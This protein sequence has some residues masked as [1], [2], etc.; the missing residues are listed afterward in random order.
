MMRND[1][2]TARHTREKTHRTPK[3]QLKAQ[4]LRKNWTQVY[5]ATMIG[6]SDVEVSRWE[7][8]AA[9]PSLYF[10][11]QLCA[12]FGTTPE[13]LGFVS[14]AETAHEEPA[15]RFTVS[16]PLPLTSLIGREQEVAAVCALL[17]RGKVRLLTLTGTGG[18]GKTRLALQVAT[19]MQKDF[20]D[21]VCFVSLA[22]LRDAA[23]VLPTIARALGLQESGTR[24]PLE[25]VKAALRGQ[26]LLL[27]L[28][29]FEHLM[30]AAPPLL[31]LLAACPFLKLL[32]TSRAVLHVRG[33]RTFVVQPLAIP[34]LH[35]LPDQE[36]LARS[37]AVALFLE[38]A[39][40]VIPDFELTEENAPLIVEL[41]Y[42][43]DGLPLAIELAAVRLTLLPLSALL[44]RLEHCLAVLTGGPR[45]LPVRQQTLRNT[46]SWSYELLSPAEQRLFRLLAVFV[47]GCTLE[48][49]EAF[50]EMLD[51]SKHTEVLDEIT[52]LL[53]KHLLY[54]IGQ[55]RKERDDRRLGMLET[56]REYGW[57]C[58]SLRGELEETRQAH[59]EYYLRLA[60][61]AEAYRYGAEQVWWFDRLEQEHDN[62]RAAL[63][64]L[65]EQ[66]EH[67]EAQE[68][69]ENALRLAGALVDFWEMRGYVDEGQAWLERILVSSEGIRTPVRAKALNGAGWLA[70]IPGTY[71]R[72]ELL[73]EES[74]ELYREARE[75]RGMALSMHWLGWI[76]LKKGNDQ[77]ARSLL[78]ESCALFRNI[79]DK[80]NL[81]Y[82]LHYLAGVSHVQGKY[83]EA[84]S[85][86]EEGLELFRKM[87]N[88]RGLAWSLRFLARVLFAQGDA[89][90][91]LALVEE[92]LTLSKEVN[93]KADIACS[94]DLLG[95][96]TLAQGDA[97]TARSLLEESLVLFRPLGGMQQHMAYTLSQL[98]SI[99][100]R[101]G[102]NRAARSWFEESLMLFLQVDDPQ[103]LANC[104]QG[105]GAMLA[106]QGEFV[107]A[108]RLWGAAETLSNVKSLR[109]LFL[110]PVEHTD[111][112][113]M[114]SLVRSQMGEH[115]FAA[116][117]AEGRTMTPVMREERCPV[118][119]KIDMM[120]LLSQSPK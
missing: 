74:L 97:L 52:S 28:D 42:R 106:R 114:V 56:I 115:A 5:V 61:E 70:T 37:G 50:P 117:W 99:A 119:Q 26:H 24:S 4:R 67:E 53:D 118:T 71:D 103:G 75:A 95:R 14:P 19:E 83:A 39:C 90:R 78:E 35:Q 11:E 59:A 9:E 27:V 46:L 18:V 40:E 82:S 120:A 21:G 49:V 13:A 110:L 6:T 68:Q 86:I 1:H 51:G 93:H 65:V 43:L 109:G 25:H 96:F 15:A 22:P 76:A 63:S 79:G 87:N 77:V 69:K 107:W 12:L 8:G 20:T 91:V 23:L 17:R 2:Q 60:E 66:A 38:R 55:G 80:G 101:E 112:E 16:L 85:L 100:T 58:L 57:E 48:A 111:Y 64:W 92:S 94:L 54:Q 3:K 116:A 33:E 45:D 29:N 73:C 108:A 31:E 10:R 104:L 98:A 84:R 88:K 72:A 62:L 89:A 7:T 47:G 36:T 30:E 44:E 113:G 32:V 34:D 102:D 41:C 105:W 81:A